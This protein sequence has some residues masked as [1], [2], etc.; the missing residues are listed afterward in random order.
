[1]LNNR[2]IAT[3][4][5]SFTSS[6]Y[7][8]PCHDN[9]SSDGG[10]L[11]TTNYKTWSVF[12]NISKLDAFDGAY[13]YTVKNGFTVLSSNK[14]AGTISAANSASYEK[15]KKIPLNISIT[16]D[17]E[18]TRI[19]VVYSTPPGTSSPEDAIKGHFCRTISAA[20]QGA[21]KNQRKL[22]ENSTINSTPPTATEAG[23]QPSGDSSQNTN[24]HI[25]NGNPCLGGVCVDDDLMTLGHIKW[26]SASQRPFQ[27]SIE[28]HKRNFEPKKHI[29]FF[30]PQPQAITDAVGPYID[31]GAF[32]LEGIEKLRKVKG[33][34]QGFGFTGYFLSESGL[35]TNVKA[36]VIPSSD[37]QAQSIRVEQITRKYPKEITQAQK[38]QL[39]DALSA[40]YPGVSQTAP[41]GS[42]PRQAVWRFDG[43]ELYLHSG[44]NSIMEK[45]D[46]FLKY[47]GCSKAVSVD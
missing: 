25:K 3:L 2:L 11:T 38:K 9:F 15:G 42:I 47:P 19:S 31:G 21:A 29:G 7:A 34:C 39:N 8:D 27:V 40:R 35:L 37:G 5:I 20:A 17:T 16:E 18:G 33:F 32:D 10:F 23:T 6:A 4:L 12:P 14:A 45:T 13:E 24:T 1:M 28:F 26:I 22:S 41:L 44:Y 36:R 46:A 30:A 43:E